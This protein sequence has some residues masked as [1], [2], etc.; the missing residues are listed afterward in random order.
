MT[1]S[2]HTLKAKSIGIDTYR[3]N[4]IFMHAECHVCRAEGFSALTRLVVKS[5]GLQIIAT[6]NVVYSDL[7]KTDE[8]ALSME[9]MKRLNVKDGDPID[10]FHLRPIESLSRLR[11]KMY[12]KELSEPDFYEIIQDVVAGHYS[13]IELAAFIAACAGDNLS[14][15]EIIGLTRAMISTSQ[16]ID[17]GRQTIL[18]KH[19]IGG[20]P[21]NRTTPII[22]SI[23]AAA[24]LSIP[25]T[26]SRAITSP[27]GTADVMETLT[28]VDLSIEKIKKVVEE[29]G[30]CLA[31]G[32]AV[33]LSPADDILIS[34]EKS[35]DVDSVGQMVASVLSKKLAAGS[36]HVLID[37]PVGETAKVR[38]QEDAIKLQYLFKA[39]AENVGI[40]TEVVLTDGSQPIG[41]GIGPA[42]EARDVL[43][44]LRNEATAPQAL[45]EKSTLLAGILLELSGMCVKG[46]GQDM[47]SKILESGEALKKFMSMCEAQGGYHDPPIA[48]FRHPVLS[49]GEG[50]VKRIDNRKLARI[51]KLAGAP[52]SAAAGIEFFAPLGKQI[53]KGDQLYVVHSDSLGELEYVKDYINASKDVI[54]IE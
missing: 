18:D 35:L 54:V 19:S 3:E 36:T 28:T 16:K 15:N 31:W 6:L 29:T 27:A 20:L 14:L 47:A 4:I 22:V 13:N 11:A 5:K 25:K 49:L 12:G 45:K 48:K 26:S 1:S 9:A 30:G 50:T 46:T 21:G 17:W 10:I 37:I 52:K 53:K 40:K 32:G 41:T 38:S 23:I 43:S 7:I 39:V 34:V 33:G 8:A 2:S 42:L 51:A 44:V 24:G